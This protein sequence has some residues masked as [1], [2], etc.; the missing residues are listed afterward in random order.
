MHTF[1]NG[2]GLNPPTEIGNSKFR[3]FEKNEKTAS[4]GGITLATALVSHQMLPDG[5]RNSDSV[6][7]FNRFLKTILFSLYHG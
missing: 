1:L 3:N 2:G 4:T 5:L 6:D 7:S